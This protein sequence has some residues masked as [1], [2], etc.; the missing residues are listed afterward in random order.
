MQ[1][2]MFDKFQYVEQIKTAPVV[3]AVFSYKSVI[4]KCFP[5]GSFPFGG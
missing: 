3:G 1:M 5:N 4:L 2:E